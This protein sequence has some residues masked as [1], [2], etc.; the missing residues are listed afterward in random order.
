MTAATAPL[1]LLFN[2]N[3][4][5][6]GS[7]SVPPD[8]SLLSGATDGTSTLATAGGSPTVVPGQTYFLGVQNTNA[9]T[10]TYS[11]AVSFGIPAFVTL[12]SG[13]PVHATNSGAGDATDYYEYVVTANAVR[14]QFEV[15]GPSGDVTLVARHGLPLPSL[16]SYDCLSANPGTNEELITLFNF[17][18]PVA[19]VPGDWFISVVNVSGGPVGYTIMAAEFPDYATN[20]V[21]TSC[22]AQTNSLC[23]TWNSV[24]NIHY[25]VQA[26]TNVTGTNWTAVS[27]SLVGADV[28][29][30]YCIPLPSPYN[31]FRVSEGL[32]VT[33]YVPPVRITSIAREANGVLLEWLAPTNSHFQVQWTPSLAPLAW[34]T[35]TNTLASTNGVFSFLDDGS[36]SGGLAGPRYYR[37]KLL[38]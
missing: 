36:Q 33:L 13:V 22:K 19:L 27:P 31:F 24:S 3:L 20:L 35:F 16:T 8:F 26:R 18:S 4:L 34:S 10:V 1:N 12:A 9:V 5:P 25:Y 29:T 38:P 11:L 21:I 32:A 2:Q 37:L 23:L 28:Q 14:A 7:N 15:D 6:T 30:S 17:S